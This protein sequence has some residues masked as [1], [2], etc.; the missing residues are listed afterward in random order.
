MFYLITWGWFAGVHFILYF[1]L[2]VLW[3]SLGGEEN[4]NAY[5]YAFWMD[6]IVT[7]L[8]PVFI[9]TE[10]AWFWIIYTDRNYE[11]EGFLLIEPILA[12]FFYGF[13]GLS[14]ILALRCDYWKAIAYYDPEER[15]KHEKWLEQ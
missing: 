5:W 1:P 11:D 3:I 8:Y 15:A 12:A 9:I 7:T 4:P 2:L 13:L 14:T 6:L 10:G